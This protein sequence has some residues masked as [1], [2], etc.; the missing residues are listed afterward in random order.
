[1]SYFDTEVEITIPVRVYYNV[2]KGYKE[3]RDEPGCPPEAEIEK[4][5][6]QEKVLKE[7]GGFKSYKLY[8][9]ELP[10]GLFRLVQE[11]CDEDLQDDALAAAEEEARDAEMEYAERQMEQKGR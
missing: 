10:P 8:H 1:M 6:V 2:S 3:T 9:H 7:E 11:Q 5:M 4:V